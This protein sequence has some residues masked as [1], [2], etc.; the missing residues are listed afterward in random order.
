MQY[1]NFID[2]AQTIAH[3][4]VHRLKE[5][6]QCTYQDP[7]KHWEKAVNF[8]E[9]PLEILQTMGDSR[10]RHDTVSQKPGCRDDKIVTVCCANH[11]IAQ[12][13]AVD[14]PQIFGWK[15]KTMLMTEAKWIIV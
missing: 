8:P 10:S 15:G 9:H 13:R 12:Q 14:I 11:I 1:D 6:S 4:R 2:D 5:F 7:N 3:D